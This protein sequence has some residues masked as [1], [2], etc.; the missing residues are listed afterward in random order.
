MSHVFTLFILFKY[1]LPEK[2]LQQQHELEK[3]TSTHTRFTDEGDVTKVQ[4]LGVCH[5]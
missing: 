2:Q 5:Y 4:K 1:F 3:C